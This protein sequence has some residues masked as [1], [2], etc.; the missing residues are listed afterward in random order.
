MIFDKPIILQKI[1]EDETWSD[2]ISLHAHVNKTKQSEYLNAGA[3]Q[4]KRTLTFTIRYSTVLEDIAYNTQNYRVLYNSNVFD[5]NDYDDYQL[6][7]KTIK[8]VGVSY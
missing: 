3:I 6:L 4:S 7:H 1:N 8:L 2:Y 5:I